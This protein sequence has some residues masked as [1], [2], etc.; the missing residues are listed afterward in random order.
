MYPGTAGTRPSI[1][2]L[3]SATPARSPLG[4][5]CPLPHRTD[6]RLLAG[7]GRSSLA[8]LVLTGHRLARPCRLD[9][10]MGQLRQPRVR[11]LCLT[12]HI[13]ARAR[14]LARLQ[15]RRLRS[16]LRERLEWSGRLDTGLIALGRGDIPDHSPVPPA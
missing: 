14:V 13:G 8:G 16:P 3:S 15:R 12:R 9:G 2:R 6:A 11:S 10:A 7:N 1:G 4:R 5:P